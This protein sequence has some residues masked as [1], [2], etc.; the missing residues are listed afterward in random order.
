MNNDVTKAAGKRRLRIGSYSAVISAVAI[1]IAVVLNLLINALPTTYTK[2]DLTSEKLYSISDQTLEVID[3]VTDTIDIYLV[4]QSGSESE[5]TLEMLHRYHDAN[6]NIK[7]STVDPVQKPTFTSQYSDADVAENSLIVV[8]RA[9]GRST[10]VDYS[11]IYNTS[12]SDEEMMY[13]YYYG[14]QPTGSTSFDGENAITSAIDYV[15]T[16]NIPVLYAVSGHGE[17]ELPSTVAGLID[18]ENI[19]VKELA[20]L[21]EDIP[22]DATALIFYSPTNDI[23]DSEKEKIESYLSEGGKLILVSQY[24]SGELQ[25]LYG[26]MENYGLE[27][28]NG[29]VIEGS[30]S[31]YYQAP[32]YL[33]PQINSSDVSAKL[34]STNINVLLR[35]AHG[36]NVLGTD[37][38][39]VSKLLSTTDSAYAKVNITEE[40]TV[41]KEDGDI[42]GPFSLGAMATKTA[43]DTGATSSVLWFSSPDI[44]TDATAEFGNHA[45]FT[46]ALTLICDKENVVSI[47]GKSL[48]AE[49]ITVNAMSST[50]WGVILV[51][52]VP[53]AVICGGF[54]VWSKRRKR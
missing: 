34:A 19:D 22:E 53:L 40:S 36:I 52:I 12:Y 39:T 23:V 48:D 6:G 18:D 51:G 42:D 49:R 14:V 33:L 24:S 17:A 54:A 26:L 30:S 9:N 8:N 47:A 1:V 50:V 7:V 2:Y 20:L 44:I 27:Y 45:F 32:Y 5:M 38:V 10:V 15:T 28:Q 37:G 46:S 25:T 35:Y 21:S 11:D 4:A 29:L 3:G 16:E 43:P 13:Y 41:E 31:G